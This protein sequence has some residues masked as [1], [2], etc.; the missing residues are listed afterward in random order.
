VSWESR[1]L[2]ELLT[3]RLEAR[4]QEAFVTLEGGLPC[5]ERL[6]NKYEYWA[7]FLAAL[8]TVRKDLQDVERKKAER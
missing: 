6:V 2:V 7:G 4:R 8:Q 5:D 3:A 1:Q